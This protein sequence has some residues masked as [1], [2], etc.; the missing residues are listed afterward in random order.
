MGILGICIE[1]G[2][3]CIIMELLSNNNF[4]EMEGEEEFEE[5]DFIEEVDNEEEEATSWKLI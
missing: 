1:P 4:E 5:E 2:F 3:E